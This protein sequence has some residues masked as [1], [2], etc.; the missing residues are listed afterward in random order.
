MRCVKF[1]FLALAVALLATGAYAQ[2][3][4]TIEGTIVD[5]T[6]AALPGVTVEVSSPEL[7]EARVIASDENGRFRVA[8][9][10]PGSYAVKFTLAGFATQEQTRITVTA[11]R[12]VTLQVQM[13][14]AYK[15]E[16]TVT[17]SLIPRPTLEA[18]APVTSVDVQALQTTGITRVEDFLTSLPQIFVAQNSSISNGA[19]GAA[20]ID[21]RS[22]GSQRTLVLIDGRRMPGAGATSNGVDVAPDL[23]FVPSALIK[24]VDILTGGASATYGADA[25]AGVVNL[26]LDKDF[27]GFKGGVQGSGFQHNN[28][29]PTAQAINAA[30]GFSYPKGNIWDGGQG[31]AYAAY[32]ANFA[33]G[34]GHVTLFLDYRKTAGMFK[35]ARDYYNC[36]VSAVPPSAACGGSS[37]AYPG[38]FYVY[39][40][41]GDYFGKYTIDS[42][43]GNTM[44]P[45]KASDAY[46]YNPTNSIQRP[47]ERWGGGGFLDYQWNQHFH[48]Y[49]EVMLMDDS[50]VAQIAPSADFLGSAG[51]YMVN[52]DNP[53]LSAQ[54]VQILCTQAGYGPHDIA[55]VLIGRRNVEGGPRQ[56]DINRIEYRLIAGL[57]GEISKG[58]NYDAYALQNVTHVTENYL[59]DLHA[60]RYQEAL[61]VSGD[62]NDPSSWQCTSGNP[63]CVP[64]DI[65]KIGGVTKAALD[66]L[67]I[68]ELFRATM[69]T[70]ILHGQVNADLK[71]YGFAFPSATEGV[72]LAL[73][74]EYRKE[75]LDSL[76]DFI[77]QNNL[78]MGTGGARLP[79]NGFYDVKEAFIE[80]QI[81]IVQGLKGAKDL[82]LNLGYRYSDYNINGSHP[83]YKGEAVYAPTGDLKFRVGY[84]R[85]TR[86]P[87]V[88][89]LF[90]PQALDLGGSVDPCAGTVPGYS[91]AQ[92]ARTG[93]T[94][95]QYG[96]I[97]EN[98]ASQYNNLY[99]GNPNLQPEIADTKAFGVVITPSGLS[100]FTATLDWYDIK[101]KNAISALGMDDILNQCALT[102]NAALCGLI[103]RDQYGSLWL[104]GNGYAVTTNQNIAKYERQGID[105]NITYS[106]PI[107]KSLLDINLI[108][109]YYN[110]VYYD[111]AIYTYDCAGLYG[112][113]CG[114]PTPK[115]RHMLRFNWETGPTTFT[116]VWRMIGSVTV[117]YASNQPALS[118][119]TF[120]PY[121]Q[122]LGAAKLPAY[123]Y[124]DLSFNYKVGKTVSFTL[125]VNNIADKEPPTGWGYANGGYSGGMYGTY[126]YAGRYIHSSVLFN[127]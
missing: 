17:G 92:C 78:G 84:N 96:H 65:F 30:R 100:G 42:T 75:F 80:A 56:D 115:W 48:G 93:V 15:E 118:A 5:E 39:G 35:S 90:Q 2:A 124:V 24:R 46:N 66:Y 117:D 18:M 106:V 76:P 55:N 82:S 81:P 101:I 58:W 86:A 73:G 25:M 83:T 123:N 45:Y 50:T 47:D 74:A 125:G 49:M 10:P 116:A 85:A 94:A 64:M 70:Q 63:A 122:A 98:P 37:N 108:G 23:D 62:P 120:V 88:G 9:L 28:D 14:S 33:D 40:P 68:P 38:S 3:T 71:Q 67:S 87:N 127:F 95:A 91:Q 43:T 69:R 8:L 51:T 126:D 59:N 52:C 110:K 41:T 7:T 16:V 6:K 119:P 61:L 36:D 109:A 77:Y 19:S 79:V 11:A 13:R 99:G 72:Q 97:P 31:E 121:Y 114:T 21:L 1:A 20:S 112:N 105:T 32:G 12:V 102:G 57:K 34:K 113:Q 26:I 104:T 44:R 27:E 89:E 107:G 111:T 60:A 54:E 103:H 29:N 4:G 22:L 53:M